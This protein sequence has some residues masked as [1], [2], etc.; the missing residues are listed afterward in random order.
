MRI[1][2][3]HVHDGCDVAA[4]SHT[5]SKDGTGQQERVEMND[6]MTRVVAMS[7]MCRGGRWSRR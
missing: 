6:L 4:L 5:R 7:K 3:Q 1:D 2:A